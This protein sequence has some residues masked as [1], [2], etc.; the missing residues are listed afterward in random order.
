MLYLIVLSRSL[1]ARD[2]MWMCVVKMTM[3]K[4]CSRFESRVTQAR[5]SSQA[6]LVALLRNPNENTLF[7]T[8]SSGKSKSIQQ[9]STHHILI[10]PKIAPNCDDEI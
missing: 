3:G 6:D 10:A 5:D 4:I 1:S 2:L 7:W 8:P 9:Q